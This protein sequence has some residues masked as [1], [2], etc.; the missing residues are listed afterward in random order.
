[1]RDRRKQ[2]KAVPP[3]AERRGHIRRR[4]P[5]VAVDQPVICDHRGDADYRRAV[6]LSAGGMCLRSPIPFRV[7]TR[8]DLDFVLPGDDRPIHCGAEVRNV[9]PSR[10]ARMN[11]VF[12]TITPWDRA[13]IVDY[14]DRI[15]PAA[16]LELDA[17][18]SLA[19]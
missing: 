16:E 14:L 7:G 3:L 8:L 10:P 17:L 19:G 13:R 15:E 4:Q 9:I 2:W 12:L 18:D 6:D 1:M 11:L 5:R